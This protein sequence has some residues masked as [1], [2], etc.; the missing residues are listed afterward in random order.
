M[1]SLNTVFAEQMIRDSSMVEQEA[2]NFK[3]LG[4]NPSR[5]AQKAT[6]WVVFLCSHERILV[7]AESH[8]SQS[9]T[10][11]SGG[12]VAEQISLKISF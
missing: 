1:V 8:V 9:E 5:G 4:S 2:V 11:S 12:L 6:Q 3:V 10:G 7:T